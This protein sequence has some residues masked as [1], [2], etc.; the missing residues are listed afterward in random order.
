MRTK[1]SVLVI[2]LS[3]VMASTAIAGDIKP[4]HTAFNGSLGTGVKKDI[5]RAVCPSPA[6]AITAVEAAVGDKAPVNPPILKV[7]VKKVSANTNCTTAVTANGAIQQDNI[8]GD[9]IL[10]DGVLVANPSAFSNVA[11]SNGSAFRIEVFK[12][13]TGGAAESYSLKYHC[14]SANGTHNMPTLTYCQNQ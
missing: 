2:S 6:S 5:L 4:L 12:T 3:A 7:Q 9:T 14:L 1:L 8:D 11:A 13:E 10:E